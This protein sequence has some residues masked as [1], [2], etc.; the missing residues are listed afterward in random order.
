MKWFLYL[1]GFAWIAVGAYV[2]LYTVQAREMYK[3]LLDGV[4]AMVL[5][6]AAAAI[7]LLLILSA[8]ASRY[9][10]VIAILG[11]IAI[12]KGIF[13]FINPK[14]YWTKLADEFVQGAS[15]QTFRLYGILALVLG[16]AVASWVG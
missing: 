11:V 8:S 13:I 1:I 10:W 14:G 16:T 9:T 7:G 6:M 12:A 5:A 15:D 4:S 3:K 2:I